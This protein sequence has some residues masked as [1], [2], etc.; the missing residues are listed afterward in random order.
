M[1][2]D[3]HDRIVTGHRAYILALAPVMPAN[4]VDL[5]VDDGGA[6]LALALEK[7]FYRRP[8]VRQCVVYFCL[9]NIASLATCL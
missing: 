6:G 8:L 1:K 9:E 2:S 3:S 7:R 5:S 4:D